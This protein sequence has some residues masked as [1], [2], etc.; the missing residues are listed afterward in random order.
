M[1]ADETIRTLFDKM[2]DLTIKL[3]QLETLLRESII[4]NQT[5]NSER[6]DRHRQDIDE[7]FRQID[8]V[9]QT[10]EHTKIKA[11]TTR[12]LIKTGFAIATASAGLAV[13]LTQ[14]IK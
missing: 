5:R 6:L 1:L 13:S 14:L 10:I 12:D 2:D 11:I 7:A 9:K 4:V 8:E 3:T